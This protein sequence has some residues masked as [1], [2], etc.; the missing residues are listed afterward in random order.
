MNTMNANLPLRLGGRDV[1]P[2]PDGD[3][4]STYE[5]IEWLEVLKREIE[6]ES[7]A[8]ALTL[9]EDMINH[10]DKSWRVMG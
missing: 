8:S 4:V 7:F 2:I 1:M 10:L 9:I 3:L 5:I 6:D